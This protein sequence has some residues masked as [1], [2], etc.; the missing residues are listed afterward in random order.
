LPSRQVWCCTGSPITFCQ[1]RS[2]HGLSTLAWVTA[3]QFAQGFHENVAISPPCESGIADIH[4]DVAT[5]PGSYCCGCHAR[6]RCRRPIVRVS[7]KSLTLILALC[8]RRQ[9]QPREATLHA[10]SRSESP[11]IWVGDLLLSPFLYWRRYFGIAGT[12]G[13]GGLQLLLARR[14]EA[15]GE[16]DPAC[17]LPP[18]DQAQG[19][20]CLVSSQACVS[21]RQNGSGAGHRGSH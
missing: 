6:S 12:R 20:H 1:L 8:G 16:I 2:S 15:R 7:G 3:V 5:P 18:S 19:W 9:L 4:R 17:Q 10:I 13:A 14:L 21:Q 11:L